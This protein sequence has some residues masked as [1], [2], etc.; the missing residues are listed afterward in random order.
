MLFNIVLTVLLIVCF[1]LV[2]TVLMQRSEGGALGIGGSGGSLISGRGAADALAR[3]TGVLGGVFLA[4]C[5]LLGVLS[6][7]E[8]PS[9]V[10]AAAKR[11]QLPAVAAPAAALPAIP[12]GA[13]GAPPASGGASAPS[14]A[15]VS[16]T[17]GAGNAPVIPFTATP[18]VPGATRPAGGPL[19]AGVPTQAGGAA[20]PLAPAKP[21]PAA[22]KPVVPAAAAPE[23][24]AP[25]APTSE[26]KP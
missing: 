23:A 20:K 4:L 6:R 15:P 2:V 21:R 11:G 3:T 19:P 5:L 16:G 12:L 1:L 24:P 7:Q 18:T 25:E 17:N 22:E 13:A 26:P 9:V 14:P 8:T 10:A